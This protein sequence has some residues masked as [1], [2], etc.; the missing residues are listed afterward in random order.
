M[1]QQEQITYVQSQIAC[2]LIEMEGMKADNKIREMRGE[3]PAYNENDFQ[4]LITK[5]NIHHN[6]VVTAL[7]REY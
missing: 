1:N 4:N 3:S 6:G 2:A 5:Y 7:T